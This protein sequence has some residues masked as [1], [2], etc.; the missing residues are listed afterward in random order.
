MQAGHARGGR[1]RAHA[2][3]LTFAVTAV[4]VALAAA[5]AMPP[6]AGAN[7]RLAFDN[8]YSQY[9]Q[10]PRALIWARGKAL[11]YRFEIGGQKRRTVRIAAIRKATGAAVK[12]WRLENVKPGER[13]A[14]TWKG[15][16]G[17]KL[18]PGGRYFFRVVDV[19]NGQSANR[20][21]S[22]GK[23]FFDLRYHQFPVKGAVSWGDGWG[24]GRGHKGQDLFASC[25]RP[26]RAARA[27]KV[28]WKRSQPS[29]AG[30]YVVIRGRRNNRDYVYMH[31]RK[32]RPVKVGEHVKTGQRIGF[33]GKTGNASGC[34]LHFELWK[35]PWFDGGR[36]MKAARKQ[37]RRWRRWS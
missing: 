35:G 8:A 17:G 7:L 37:L 9:K 3:R 23:R 28:V 31:L 34:H 16:N 19:A 36:A 6:A 22:S 29:A 12:R 10:H 4:A 20:D 11:R 25:G 21:K 27:G 15:V 32:R 26:I 14:V 33:M 2:R 13:Q 18:A 5:S 1:G 30:Y 24:A